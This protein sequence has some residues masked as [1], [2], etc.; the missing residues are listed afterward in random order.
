M[1]IN[2]VKFKSECR[3]SSFHVPIAAK[4]HLKFCGFWVC[5]FQICMVSWSMGSAEHG[6]AGRSCPFACWSNNRM[7]WWQGIQSEILQ[8]VF[9][10]SNIS[11]FVEIVFVGV[12]SIHFILWGEFVDSKPFNG[13]MTGNWQQCW[14]CPVGFARHQHCDQLLG[15]EPKPFARPTFSWVHENEGNQKPWSRCDIRE[16]F[17]CETSIETVMLHMWLEVRWEDALSGRKLSNCFRLDIRPPEDGFCLEIDG[18]V[19]CKE[20]W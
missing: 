18:E 11:P 16:A 2:W 19:G 20:W 15:Y 17:G 9:S 14:G 6:F 5:F 8:V 12:V 3:T 7:R 13:S 10:D 1:K 4:F